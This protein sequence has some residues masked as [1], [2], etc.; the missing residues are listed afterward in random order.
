MI[1]RGHHSVVKTTN[2]IMAQDFCTISFTTGDN[3]RT[4]FSEM[5]LSTLT[6]K[7]QHA[8]NQEKGPFVFVSTHL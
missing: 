1:T 5:C 4:A 6:E 7:K 3:F 8:N 2:L